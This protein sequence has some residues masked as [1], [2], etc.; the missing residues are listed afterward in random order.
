MLHILSLSAV[1]GGRAGLYLHV[2]CTVSSTFRRIWLVSTCMYLGISDGPFSSAKFYMLICIQMYA[3][4]WVPCSAAGLTD[5][6]FACFQASMMVL[7][8]SLHSHQPTRRVWGQTNTAVHPCP[9][10]SCPSTPPWTRSVLWDMCWQH[11]RFHM[12][13]KDCHDD[14]GE[15]DDDDDG[16]GDRGVGDDDDDDF[17]RTPLF[18]YVFII[19]IKCS[20]SAEMMEGK[21]NNTKAQWWLS[22]WWVDA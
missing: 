16:D 19:I 18:M 11:C 13:G 22:L 2:C 20:L 15:D 21:S 6:L 3:A 4:R 10:S 14:D 17:C 12:P 7:Q 5:V 9:R 1:F 8:K